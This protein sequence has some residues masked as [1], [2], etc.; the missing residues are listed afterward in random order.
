M[1]HSNYL[2]TPEVRA[3]ANEHAGFND[4][5]DINARKKMSS[6]TRNHRKCSLS[7]KR[8]WNKKNQFNKI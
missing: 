3:G 7:Y 4:A 1:S 5:P 8:S 6:P 2:G